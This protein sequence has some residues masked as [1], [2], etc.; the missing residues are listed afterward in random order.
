MIMCTALSCIISYGAWGIMCMAIMQ[1]FS[2]RLGELRLG[3]SHSII[4]YMTQGIIRMEQTCHY[5]SRYSG[6]HVYG[7]ATPSYPMRPKDLF[8]WIRYA[9]FSYETLGIRYV[10]GTFIPSFLMR[11]NELFV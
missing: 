10:F 2:R 1:S 11:P 5:F 8:V 4:S 6:N 9:I 3:Y 7:T